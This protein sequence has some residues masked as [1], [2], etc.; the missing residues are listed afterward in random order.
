MITTYILSFFTGYLG[1][2]AGISICPGPGSDCPAHI[3]GLQKDRILQVNSIRELAKG[4]GR[5][6]TS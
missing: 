4:R 6:S 5:A 1:R 2:F 3:S